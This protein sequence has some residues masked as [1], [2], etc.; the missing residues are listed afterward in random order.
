[1]LE[2]HFM[3]ENRRL[4]VFA[5]FWKIYETSVSRKPFSKSK[6]R[7]IFEN[8]GTIFLNCETTCD[9]LIIPASI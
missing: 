4:D 7:E 8:H 5:L 6:N 1:M 3:I 9:L 2:L